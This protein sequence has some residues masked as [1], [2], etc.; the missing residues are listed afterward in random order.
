MG[1]PT[2]FGTTEPGI[3]GAGERRDE[4]GDRLPEEAG[5]DVS[6]G[7]GKEEDHGEGCRVEPGPSEAP[8][9]PCEG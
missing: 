2:F 1:F 4:F 6:G 5:D 9:G 7:R 8:L 3:E